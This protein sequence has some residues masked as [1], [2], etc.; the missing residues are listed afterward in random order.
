[1]GRH[2][3]V[4]FEVKA[5]E[6]ERPL[7]VVGDLFRRV[8]ELDHAPAPLGGIRELVCSAS[9]KDAARRYL[10]EMEASGI[11]PALITQR[12][13]EE[14]PFTRV[15]LSGELALLPPDASLSATTPAQ[16]KICEA[17]LVTARRGDVEGFQ[18]NDP[19]RGRKRL[20]LLERALAEA[21]E[22]ID[23]HYFTP[24]HL[25]PPHLQELFEIGR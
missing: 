9:Y 17:A 16:A 2:P 21:V 12:M 19:K 24:A 10:Q 13:T 1:M 14:A 18:F 11:N 3:T 20:L 23:C 8:D 7:V 15:R 4:G 25:L 6:Q 5:P 22:V